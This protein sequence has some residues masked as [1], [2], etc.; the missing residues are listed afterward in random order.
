[1]L[2]EAAFLFIMF[3]VCSYLLL[4]KDFKHNMSLYLVCYGIFRFLIEYVRDDHRGTL[5]GFITPSQF[6]SLLMVVLGVALY[7]IMEK[8]LKKNAPTEESAEA[9][10]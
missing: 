4:K 9:N 1:M 8:I 3:A 6:W 2:Y 10:E 7:F 5:L